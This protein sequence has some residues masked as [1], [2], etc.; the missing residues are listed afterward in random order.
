MPSDE[1]TRARTTLLGRA[2]RWCIAP[3]LVLIAGI[4]W[5]LSAARFDA[6]R[7]GAE[8]AL[9]DA[10]A[11]H[12]AYFEDEANNAVGLAKS[13][14]DAQV[15]GLFGQRALSLAV[16]RR[17]VESN[18]WCL[19]TYLCYEPDADGRDLESLGAGLPAGALESG[20]RFVPYWFRDPAKGGAL[21]LK[22]NVELETSLYYDGARRAFAATGKA[23]PMVTEPYLYDG[24]L[25][26]EQTYPIV[27]DGRFRGIAG[28]DRSLRGMKDAVEEIARATGATVYLVSGRGRFVATSLAEDR[29]GGAMPLQTR[30]VAEGPLRSV[31]A[32]RGGQGVEGGREAGTERSARRRFLRTDPSPFDGAE[33]YWASA[34]I[35]TGGWTLVLARPVED[36]VGPLWR[37]TAVTGIVSI[38]GL[39]VPVWLLVAMLVSHARRIGA[40]VR[41]SG[42]VA[43]GDLSIE[44]PVDAR[45]DEAGVLLRAVAAM[46]EGLA[47]LVL[48]I[49]EAL[50]ALQIAAGQVGAAGQSQNETLA[51]IDAS[52]SEIAA[53]VHEIRRSGEELGL[54]AA[55]LREIADGSGA[56][57][58]GGRD[59][60]DALRASMESMRASSASMSER[61]AVISSRASGITAIG[62]TIER[63]AEQTNLLSVNAAIEAEKAGEHGRGF[64]VVAREI[65]RLANETSGAT[66]EI[67]AI[68]R[69]MQGAVSSGVM[70]M[71][72]F[73][74]AVETGAGKAAEVGARLGGIVGHVDGSA[75]RIRAIDDGVRE[76]NLGSARIEETM[77]R[78]RE[79]AAQGAGAAAEFGVAAASMQASLRT[80]R[81]VVDAF[82]LR[83]I[84]AFPPPSAAPSSERSDPPR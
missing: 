27:I 50:A 80:L 32:L 37:E 19:G 17:A 26:V 45:V 71:D 46:R 72:R 77:R 59:S 36:V 39:S 83:A 58:A 33:T 30:E 11:A 65:R 16:L 41:A 56:L 54:V 43:S 24:D 60:M 81:E 23:A 47:R 6:L 76:Q 42:A 4:V 40:A 70:E 67:E 8:T 10:A 79:R 53:A 7:A 82:R 25:L 22:P 62:A 68:L 13:L 35:P 9:L 84:P 34:E 69:E 29:E 73:T 5:W 2:L 38:V 12:A 1:P 21:S 48:R 57:A 51:E 20:G 3:I 18:P 31:P 52:A 28:A 64:L 78:L 75:Q 61:L 49:R 44:V 74:R 15:A 55:E 63:V 14:A 66:G